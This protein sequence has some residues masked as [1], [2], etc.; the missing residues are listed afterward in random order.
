[1]IASLL[2]Y[3]SHGLSND[4]YPVRLFVCL[5]VNVLFILLPLGFF[6]EHSNLLIV[7][8]LLPDICNLPCCCHCSHMLLEPPHNLVNHSFALLQIRSYYGKCM[9]I[10]VKSTSKSTSILPTQSIPAQTSSN[11][12]YT[13]T[14]G[15]S[16]YSNENTRYPLFAN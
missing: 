10:L 9:K 15:I 3:F 13:R 2:K 7:I 1:M 8:S 11:C 14:A 4:G 6:S 5:S 16:R 12:S